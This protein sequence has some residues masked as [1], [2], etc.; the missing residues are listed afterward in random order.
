MN[1]TTRNLTIA[2]TAFGG[3]LAGINLDRMIVQIPALHQLGPKAWADYSRHADLSPRGLA[4][5]PTIGIGHAVLSVAAALALHDRRARPAAVAAATLV[6][7]GMATTMKAAPSCSPFVTSETTEKPWS[8]HGGVL[9][10]GAEFARSV[11][12]ARLLRTSGRSPRRADK[13][14]W[15]DRRGVRGNHQCVFHERFR[16]TRFSPVA[17]FH[18][19]RSR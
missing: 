19:M 1:Q 12:W 14:G 8:V 7:G 9:H 3:I 16:M 15:Q 17:G 18:T 4:L 2:A 10:F 6:L 13:T 5:Y 11:R